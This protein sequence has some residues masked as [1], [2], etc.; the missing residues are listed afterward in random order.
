M[1]QTTSTI[2]ISEQG[3]PP[4]VLPSRGI[5]G[6]VCLIIAESAIFIIFVVAYVY[7]IGK[8]LSGP[9]PA[10]VLELPDRKSVV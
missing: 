10:Q 3:E 6:I 8:S 2:P 9:M 7:Y 5:V 1:M 4:W